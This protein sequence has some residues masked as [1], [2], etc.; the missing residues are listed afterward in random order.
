MK[1][2]IINYWNLIEVLE[3]IYDKNG[4]IISIEQINYNYNIEYYM[5]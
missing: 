2:T 3:S 4:I 5:N 1:N